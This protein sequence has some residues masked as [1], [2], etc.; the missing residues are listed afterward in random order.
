MDSH[1]SIDVL[2]SDPR[3]A[4]LA[5]ELGLPRVDAADDTRWLLAYHEDRLELRRPGT[6]PGRGLCAAARSLALAGLSRQPLVRAL[7]RWQQV[8]DATAGLGQD[9]LLLEA[10]GAQV[11]AI[12]RQPVMAALLADGLRRRASSI[13]LHAGDALTLLAELPPAEAVYLD[14]M[15]PPRRKAA[16]PK[17]AARLI[18]ELAGDDLDADQLFAVARA[19]ATRR[20]IVKRPRHAPELGGKPDLV[21]EGKLARFD[22]YLTG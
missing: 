17:L 3:A 5:A 12:E 9:A 1:P 15:Y 14:P 4:P 11:R 20:V 2:V 6:R 16:L 22:I 13:A 21:Q 10:A 7:G 19:H 18:R 8:I